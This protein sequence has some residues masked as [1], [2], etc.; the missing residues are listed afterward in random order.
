MLTT[1]SIHFSMFDVMEH[2]KVLPG[3]MDDAVAACLVK[4]IELHWNS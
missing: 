3:E 2:S 4:L 1:Q